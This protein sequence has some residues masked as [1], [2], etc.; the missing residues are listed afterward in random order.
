MVNETNPIKEKMSGEEHIEIPFDMLHLAPPQAA[1]KFIRES[2][3]ANG[4]GWL[5]VDHF[6]L[7]HNK[8][9]NVFGVGD[10]AGLPTAKTGAA[11]RKQV[12]VMLE[13]ILTLIDH[14]H[15]MIETNH[16]NLHFYN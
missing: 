16:I 8:F 9:P 3:L 4:A 15:T 11:I 7:Q 5:D 14:Y 13:N 6:T 2:P 1:P 12:P 10:A